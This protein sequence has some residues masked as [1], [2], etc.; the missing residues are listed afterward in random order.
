MSASG[1]RA[2]QVRE[3]VAVAYGNCVKQIL[4]RQGETLSGW[5]SSVL[6]AACTPLRVADRPPAA[7]LS[8]L[9]W[10]SAAIASAP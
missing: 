3:L 9:N 8:S 4:Q 5:T 1:L 7:Q 6:C 10:S 2:G